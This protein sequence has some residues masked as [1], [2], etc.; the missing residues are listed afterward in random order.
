MPKYHVFADGVVTIPNDL[1]TF[2]EALTRFRDTVS[3][4]FSMVTLINRSGRR[5]RRHG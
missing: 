2:R 1:L 4:G 3:A 5:L